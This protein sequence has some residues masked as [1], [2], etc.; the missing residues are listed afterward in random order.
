M[1]VLLMVM[2]FITGYVDQMCQ[3]FLS[4]CVFFPL[5]LFSLFPSIVF[6][7]IIMDF[8]LSLPVGDTFF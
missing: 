3:S 5:F 7:L 8:D 2:S 6:D 4:R 1:I